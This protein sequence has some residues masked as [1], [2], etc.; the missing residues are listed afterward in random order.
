LGGLTCA[1]AD[2][3]AP[4][5]V[6]GALDPAEAKSVRAHLGDCPERHEA[7]AAVGGTVGYLAELAEPVEPPPAL[8]ARL[9]SAVADDLGS[10]VSGQA[11]PPTA[12][13]GSEA[14]PLAP[15]GIEAEPARLETERARRRPVLSFVMAA[16]AV[17]LIVV[18]A[19][20]NLALRGELDAAAE[21]AGILRE[22]IAAVGRP[23]A[24][25][26]SVTGTEAQPGASGFVVIPMEGDGYLAVH[27][28]IAPPIGQTY[29]A[30]TIDS[31]GVPVA[32]GLASPHDGL[33]VFVLPSSRS[34]EVVALTLEPEGGSTTPTMPIQ[35]A[36]EVG[37]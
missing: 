30:W 10:R 2:E 27:G 17:L 7:F 13:T 31:S 25:V 11:A 15:S 32:A 23:G 33:A 5:F 18:L 1:E 34:A 14:M 37:G 21:Q 35:V 29:E 20:S 12:A 22:A 6:L 24:R 19:A 4:A 26:A 28:L 3:L 9:M 16:A 8:K 36:G